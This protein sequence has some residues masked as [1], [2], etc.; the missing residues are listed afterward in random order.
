MPT[1]AG[2]ARVQGWPLGL[3]IL[4]ALLAG[5]AQAQV[6]VPPDLHGWEGWVLH[7]KQQHQCPWLVPGKPADDLRVCAWPGVLELGADAH[8][9]RFSQHWEVAAEGWLPL[10]GDADA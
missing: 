2:P 9:A 3:L 5:T 8:G 7:G 1:T 4:L 6:A 10:P